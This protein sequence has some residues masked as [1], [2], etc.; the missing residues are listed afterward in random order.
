M[1]VKRLAKVT[2]S[3]TIYTNNPSILLEELSFEKYVFVYS[4][5]KQL[6]YSQALP[7]GD[8]ELEIVRKLA[9]GEN[10][11]VFELYDRCGNK[12]TEEIVLHRHTN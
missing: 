12:T 6:D 11:M 8:Y 2:C 1:T 9:P 5:G 10:K 3:G 7:D 4:N